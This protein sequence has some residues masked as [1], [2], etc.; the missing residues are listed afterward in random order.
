LFSGSAVFNSK[1]GVA[2]V[3]SAHR[4]AELFISTAQGA[5]NTATLFGARA[6]PSISAVAGGNAP[7]PRLVFSPTLGTVK[8]L[9]IST[10]SGVNR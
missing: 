6:V 7:D 5:M 9:G 3:A 1:T 4:D 2:E 8:D 10:S